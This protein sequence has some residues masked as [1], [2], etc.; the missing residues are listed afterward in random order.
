MCALEC[1]EISGAEVPHA[2]HH[3]VTPWYSPQN[4]VVSWSQTT[5]SKFGNQINLY[6]ATPSPKVQEKS[7]GVMEKRF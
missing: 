2:V 5:T 4:N 3:D 1:G 7:K 6:P